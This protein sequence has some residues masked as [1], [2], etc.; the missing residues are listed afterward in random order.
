M[1]RRP[2]YEFDREFSGKGFLNFN[3]PGTRR[4]S[5]EFD[6]RGN[7]AIFDKKGRVSR[8]QKLRDIIRLPKRK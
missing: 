1:P 3:V 6:S 5:I 2:K 4:T 8:I 7:V